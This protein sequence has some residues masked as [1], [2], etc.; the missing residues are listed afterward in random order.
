MHDRLREFGV[1]AAAAS[2]PA[3]LDAGL[4]EVAVAFQRAGIRSVLLKGPAVAR[5]LYDPSDSRRY[6]DIDLLLAA[7]DLPLAGQAL[8]GLGFS[9]LAE[10]DP[11]LIVARRHEMWGRASD[12]IVVELHWT[13]VNSGVPA[14]EV[15]SV[16]SEQ[17]RRIVVDGEPVEI[18]S[19]PARTMHLALH[20]VHHGAVGTP[21][22]DLRRGIS[23]LEREVWEQARDLAVRLKWVSPFAAG[24]RT[25]PEGRE[26]AD[27]LGL[28]E[29]FIYWRLRGR[30][31]ETAGRLWYLR[32]AP[33]WHDRWRLVRWFLP[34]TRADAGSGR[35][36]AIVGDVARAVAAVAPRVRAG[37][38]RRRASRAVRRGRR[39]GQRRWRRLPGTHDGE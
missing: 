38:A 10:P 14:S 17:T 27:R 18:L 15:W 30:A 11:L 36:W 24:L 4:A 8:G 23:Q 12:G 28:P 29:A 7:P 26:L 5:W 39:A 25:C 6:S 13:L 21:R 31:P 33:S 2:L 3:K 9:P 35:W 19:V 20:A 34:Q 32:H 22:E 1:R 37:L 16:L